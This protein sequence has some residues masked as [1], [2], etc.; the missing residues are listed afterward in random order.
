VDRVIAVLHEPGV[1][2]QADPVCRRAILAP[3]EVMGVDAFCSSAVIIKARFK[4]VPS[5]QWSVGREFN[6][7]MKIR[8]D[9]LGVEMPF[10]HLRLYLGADRQGDGHVRPDGELV[11]AISQAMRDPDGHEAASA[12][13]R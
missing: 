8:F 6:R 4:T 2:L 7:R 11:A 9:E 5:E 12:G 1:A 3:L 10:P 13:E